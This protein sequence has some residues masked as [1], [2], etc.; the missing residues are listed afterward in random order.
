MKNTNSGNESKGD[1]PMV[2]E[3]LNTLA[4]AGYANGVKT[5]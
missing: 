5:T 2:H 4:G 3:R 1:R